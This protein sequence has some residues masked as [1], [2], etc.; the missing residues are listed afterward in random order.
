[1]LLQLGL[2]R[3]AGRVTLGQHDEGQNDFTADR[4][5][6]ADDGRFDHRRMFDERA[7]D[8]KTVRSGKR[9]C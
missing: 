7:L 3:L 2:E 9:R 4:I 8:L 1:V 6:P 5:G